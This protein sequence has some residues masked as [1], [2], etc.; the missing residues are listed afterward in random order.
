MRALPYHDFEIVSPLGAQAARDAISAQVDSEKVFRI[1]WQNR[2]N[3]K[4][5]E[6][7]VGTD[8]FHLRRIISYRNSF[9]PVIDGTIQ[10]GASGSRIAVKMRMFVFVYV[11]GAI[12]AGAALVAI[13]NAGALGL[14]IGVGLLLFFYAMTMI[15]FW[16]EAGK[17][18]RKLRAIFQANEGSA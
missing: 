15:G 3:V 10:G 7:T 6:G 5:F 9:L 2:D 13:V 4:Y 12:W 17:Q 14:A 11:F 18:E 8:G 16:L 1:G